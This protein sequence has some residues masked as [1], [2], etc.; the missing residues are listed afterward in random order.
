MKFT[1]ASILLATSAL[2]A[3]ANVERSNTIQISG[4]SAIA[5]KINSASM[6]FV[7]TDANY[8]DDTP[9]DCQLL[10]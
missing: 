2:A 10:W 8:P 5:S 7:V 3:P 4:F 9:T 1:I 6:H